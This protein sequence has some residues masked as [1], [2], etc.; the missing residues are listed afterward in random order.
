MVAR[1]IVDKVVEDLLDVRRQSR[2]IVFNRQYVV[3]ALVHDV[4][5]DV[6][7]AADGIDSNQSAG[8]IE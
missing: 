8:E 3:T 5:G 6:L 1:R 2:L 4:A 7:L